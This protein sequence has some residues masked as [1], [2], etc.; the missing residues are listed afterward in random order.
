MKIPILPLIATSFLITLLAA[1]AFAQDRRSSL[2][3]ARVDFVLG[4]FQ[5]TLLHELAHVAIGDLDV[6]ILGPEEFAADYLATLVLIQPIQPSSF[7]A[8]ERRGFAVTAADAFLAM[9]QLAESH[10]VSPPYWDVHGL[11]IQRFYTIACLVYGSNPE[12]F[13]SVPERAQMPA[14]RSAGCPSEYARARKSLEWLV[15]FAERSGAERP[16]ATMSVRYEPA[17]SQTSAGITN[18]IRGIRLVER[19]LR[20]FEKTVPLDG[21]AEVVLRACG[22]PEAAWHADRREL[23]LC[24]ELLDMYYL[25][26]A[27]RHEQA[28]GTLR[29]EER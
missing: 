24:Y 6:P 10:G 12:R 27:D 28:I 15:S 8:A 20:S 11:S 17:H 16:D 18:E 9:W 21:D 26:G 19:T 2:D 23:V 25:L 3:P 5:F 13:A 29:E 22:I 14:L 1:P 7:D 4:S